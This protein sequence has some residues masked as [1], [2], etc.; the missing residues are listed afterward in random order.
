MQTKGAL[1]YVSNAFPGAFLKNI[2]Y[3]TLAGTAVTVDAKSDSYK[4]G[5]IEEFA[6]SSYPQVSGT[7]EQEQVGDGVV[8]L[9]AAHLPG[10]VQISLPGVYH[11]INAP[12]GNWYGGDDVIDIWLG[13]VLAG[14]RKC[15]QN[16]NQPS[17][18][19]LDY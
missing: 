17:A 18:L 13:A 15:I 9:S 14:Y 1:T 19:L 16:G 8:P 7:S 11:S 12:N 4:K 6:S 5:S 2:F 10:A 3:V